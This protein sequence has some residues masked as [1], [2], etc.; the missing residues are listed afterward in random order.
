MSTRPLPEDTAPATGRAEVRLPCTDLVA[1]MRFFQETLG[2]RLEEI[3]PADDPRVALVSGHGLYLRLQLDAPEA[4]ATVRILSDAPEQL[5]EGQAQLVSPAGNR[6]EVDA[7]NPSYTTPVPTQEFIVRR[8][9]DRAPWVIGRAGMQYRDLIPGR[10][11]G[12]IIASHIR[13]PEG[14]PV[15]DMVHYHVVGFQL[16][17][18]YRGW[19]RL[20]YEDQ[21]EPFILN[22]GDCV[23]QPPQIRH[24]V[25][26]ASDG[27]QVIEIGV[28]AEH[29]TTI[30]H[31]M[32]LP[33]ATV[34]RER[35]FQGQRFC[36]HL[37]EEA[38]WQAWRLP[39][40]EARDTG[41]N[42]TSA[43][44]AGV[45]VARYRGD[46]DT[47]SVATTHDADILFSFILSGSMVLHS[48]AGAQPLGTGEAFVLPRGEPHRYA[49]CS[50]DLELLE[51][52]LPG[53][54]ATTTA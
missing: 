50:D 6:V 31:D 44:V 35:E 13:I 10:L 21:G 23:T 1:E 32:T 19:V 33:T 7:L 38:V 12:S 43:G 29:I 46:A 51:V 34:N 53:G 42:D 26:E 49:E 24:R 9:V 52:S 47:P 48:T 8:L 15:P 11:G 54:F 40:F 27:L 5:A 14:G 4:P 41:V 18:C 20:V 17:Y 28:P 25:L 2:F 37:L 36:H 45:Q 22:A 39:G 30:D 3:Y 16:I